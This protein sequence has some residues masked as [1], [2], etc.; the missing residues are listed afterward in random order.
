MISLQARAREKK[1]VIKLNCVNDKLVQ[2]KAQMNIADGQSS[3]LQTSLDRRSPDAEAQYR[4]LRDT[5]ERIGKLKEEAA[6]CMGETELFKQESGV[7]VERPEIVDDPTSVDPYPEEI[8]PPA[9][10]SPFS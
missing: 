6:A 8:E 1:D 9:Y 2:A 3:T 7:E 4:E 10:A 5:N